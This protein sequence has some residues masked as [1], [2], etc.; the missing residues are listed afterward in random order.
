MINHQNQNHIFFSFLNEREREV[1]AIE[2]EE[3]V[4]VEE[5]EEIQLVEHA[6]IG[7]YLQCVWQKCHPP[8]PNPNTRKKLTKHS[9]LVISSIKLKR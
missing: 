2:D 9:M 7:R 8:N 3:T 6:R 1:L 4:V 5:V